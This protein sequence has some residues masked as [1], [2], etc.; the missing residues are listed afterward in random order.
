[1]LMLFT[2]ALTMTLSLLKVDML[3]YMAIDVAPPY[4]AALG[5]L[6]QGV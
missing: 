1:M 5:E 4:W 2:G 6:A 3:G